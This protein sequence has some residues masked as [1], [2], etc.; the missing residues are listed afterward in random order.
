MPKAVLH[1]VLNLVPELSKPDVMK[2]VLEAPPTDSNG[3]EYKDVRASVL[4]IAAEQLKAVAEEIEMLSKAQ[5]LEEA[6]VR[7]LLFA[8]ILLVYF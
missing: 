2:A 5:A 7:L 6:M 8:F 3:K 4:L 1:A